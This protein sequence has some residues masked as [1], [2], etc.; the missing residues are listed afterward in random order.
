MTSSIDELIRIG[1]RESL[2]EVMDE[3]DDWMT[4]LDAAEGLLKLND[5]RGL[6]FLLIARESDDDEIA[7]VAE[8]IL[9]KPNAQRMIEQMEM[10]RRAKQKERIEQAKLRLQQ[11]KK[12]FAYKVVYV[13]SGDILLEDPLGE[14]FS[15]DELEQVGLE[16]WEVVNIIP[17]YKKLLAL[18]LD[19][20]IAGAYF[21]LK[22]EVSSQTELPE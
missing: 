14:G 2:N 11:N 10:T 13:A 22:R 15:I 5:S 18:G 4:Q 12:V 7:S 19:D 3:S 21:F 20:H 17:R 1:D 6:E 9:Q 8:E 16:G